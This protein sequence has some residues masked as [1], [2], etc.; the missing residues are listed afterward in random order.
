[1]Q[2][3]PLFGPVLDNTTMW[4]IQKQWWF[5]GLYAFNVHLQFHVSVDNYK[6]GAY[7]EVLEIDQDLE[8]AHEISVRIL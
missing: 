6:Q 8:I 3:N 4:I 7:L 5:Q 1:M 2:L